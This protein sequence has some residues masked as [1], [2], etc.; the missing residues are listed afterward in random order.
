MERNGPS[1]R[2]SSIAVGALVV[3]LMGCMIF[4]LLGAGGCTSQQ[5]LAA[6]SG[7]NDSKVRAETIG[8][9]IE[10]LTAQLNKALQDAE[11]AKASGLDPIAY[12]KAAQEIAAA[13]QAK[14]GLLEQ[15]KEEIA[16]A[17]EKLEALDTG[18][19]KFWYIAAGIAGAFVT[20]APIVRRIVRNST[21]AGKAIARVAEKVGEKGSR[22]GSAVRA[23]VG[24]S[25]GAA[26]AF[27]KM[28]AER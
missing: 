24:L 23:K 6:E 20:G 9:E 21:E 22:K 17:G 28:V 12:M 2:L 19:E 4:M 13:I 1:V 18:W 8:S 26:K 25:D 15:V 3:L 14:S 27:E 7:F 10:E 5:R 11:A 16:E